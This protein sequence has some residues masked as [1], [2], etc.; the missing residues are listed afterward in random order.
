[1]SNPS[2]RAAASSVVTVPRWSAAT[3]SE[4][5]LG[6]GAR[7]DVDG[8][9]ADVGAGSGSGLARVMWTPSTPRKSATADRTGPTRVP[10][11]VHA[12]TIAAATVNARRVGRARVGGTAA[13]DA[14]R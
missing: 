13:A 5:T 9:G 7:P 11:S 6:A 12:T 1:M 2:V 8:D 14:R 3:G 10:R 4:G